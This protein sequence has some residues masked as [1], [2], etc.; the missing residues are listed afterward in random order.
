MPDDK[1]KNAA[2]DGGVGVLPVSYGAMMVGTEQVNVRFFDGE[3]S[4]P[5][6]YAFSIGAVT[7]LGTLYLRDPLENTYT[8]GVLVGAV[9][10]TY[11]IDKDNAEACA[12]GVVKVCLRIKFDERVLEARICSPRLW[13]PGWDCHGW[14]R[15]ASW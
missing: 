13:P 6:P 8:D 3:K 14:K 12:T 4:V 9:N 1:L 5:I 2:N 11:H 15:I 10:G 7:I